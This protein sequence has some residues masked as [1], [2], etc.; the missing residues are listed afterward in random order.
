MKTQHSRFPRSGARAGA[1]TALTHSL[2]GE[3]L[4]A[5]GSGRFK[6]P[7]FTTP[8]WSPSA[9][10]WMA[11]VNPGFVNEQTLV[12][13]A[14]VEEQQT[15]GNP[16]ENNPLTGKPFFSDSVF[17][18]PVAE[19]KTRAVDLPLYLEPTIPLDFRGVG[20]DGDPT[21]PVPQFFLDLGV[22]KAPRQPSPE[23][24]LDGLSNPTDSAP[25]ADLRLLRACDLWLHQPRLALTSDITL[26]PGPATGISNVTQTLGLRSPAPNDA[27]R[28]LQGTFTPFTSFRGGIDPLAGD[29]EEPAYDEL[30]ISTVYLLSPPN[31][32]LG[33][34]PDPTWRPYV[35]HHL[36]WNLN[37]AQPGFR[38]LPD[39]PNVPFI[40]PLAGGAAQL[41]INFLTASLNDMTQQSL[42]ILTGHSMAGHFWTPTGGGKDATF[43]VL[44]AAQKVKSGP[45]R[46]ANRTAQIAAE[47]TAKR[48]AQLDPGFPYNA[49]PFPTS[50]L[51]A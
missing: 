42:N 10:R 36:F 51:S 1:R 24:L 13:R 26:Q 41:V 17:S 28:I 19:K 50:L 11:T 12:F 33:S 9:N 16:W 34:E 23:D 20:F 6:H 43:A 8:A 5:R 49:Q 35:R 40:P 47:Q 32:P 25:P 30:L 48:I 31:V 37:W 14:T 39:D 27:L 29:Y 3:A 45:D 38:P 21:A 7:W 18:K 46:Q 22:A 2:L 4:S 44:A 15:A